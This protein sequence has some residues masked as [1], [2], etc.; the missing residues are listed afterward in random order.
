MDFQTCSVTYFNYLCLRTEHA[1]RE[2]SNHE[3][4][5]GKLQNQGI[6]CLLPKSSWWLDKLKEAFCEIH[7]HS[8]GS[9]E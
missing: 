1:M 7:W 3:Q 8:L 5:D 2:N 6:S 9:C 4:C